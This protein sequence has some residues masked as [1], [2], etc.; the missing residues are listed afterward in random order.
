MDGLCAPGLTHQKSKVVRGMEDRG[1]VLMNLGG[2]VT[3]MW[4]RLPACPGCK[5]GGQNPFV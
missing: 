3:A 5:V 2:A 4:D 1:L